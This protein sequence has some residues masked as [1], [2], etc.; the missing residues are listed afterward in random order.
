MGSEYIK[1]LLESDIEESMANNPVVAILGPRQCGKTT[2]SK[3]LLAQVPNVLFL[4]LERPSDLLK[5]ADVEVF[6]QF[7][8]DKVFC[9]D[10]VQLKPDLFPVLRSI[11]DQ[12]RRNGRFLVLGSASR[13]LIRQSSETLAGRIAYHEL[14]PFVVSELF[15]ARAA[16]TD[17]LLRLLLRGGFPMSY[18]ATSERVS[19]NWRL[20]FIRTFLERDI[21]NLDLRIP[22]ATL[23]RLWRMLAH[24]HGQVFNSSQIGASLGVS[25]TTARKYSDLLAETFMIRILPP[26]EANL[27]KR[28]IKSPKV[29][30]R[31][32]GLLHALLGIQ[33]QNE[34]FSHPVFGASWEGLV[35]DTVLISFPH[36]EASYLR[37]A[38]GNEIDLVLSRG[39]RRVA[40]EC[41]A[42]AAPTVTKGF[43]NALEL[44]Q[45]E[46]A[47]VV[48]L[49]EGMY[50]IKPNVFVCSLPELLRVLRVAGF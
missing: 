14:A 8:H 50:P 32:S 20:N 37:T 19:L 18:L 25:H 42:S 9:I 38:H 1:R 31:D 3:R 5:L 12:E 46:A 10:E 6:L 4:D 28:L 49:V 26:F 13:D 48:G 11:I 39:N 41:K 47:Y 44:I 15:A 24:V 21:P 27:P 2:L 43:W 23:E 33:D 17:D 35:V 22:A 7:H 45:P 16:G 40:I 29:Y 34:L 36:W 30:L